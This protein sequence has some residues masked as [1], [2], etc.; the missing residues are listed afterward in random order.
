MNTT[1]VLPLDKKDDFVDVELSYQKTHTI[2]TNNNNKNENKRRINKMVLFGGIVALTVGGAVIASFN[3]KL[4]TITTTTGDEIAVVSS[5][6]TCKQTPPT[7]WSGVSDGVY[8]TCWKNGPNDYQGNCYTNNFSDSSNPRL[9]YGCKPK[10]GEWQTTSNHRV[11]KA[12]CG[13]Q[14]TSLVPIPK[15]V[16]CSGRR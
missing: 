6:Y 13:K 10:G 16:P 14:C 15:A 12:T 2:A 7:P 5:L 9:Y 1:T 8:Q 4:L 11:E 3:S